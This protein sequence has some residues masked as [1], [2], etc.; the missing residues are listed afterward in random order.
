VADR[1]WGGGGEGPHQ[2]ALSSA[3]DISGGGRRSASR[4]GG[5]WRGWSGWSGWGQEARCGVEG[6]RE[7]LEESNTE[8]VLAVALDLALASALGGWA[9][10]RSTAQR[11]ALVHGSRGT[12]G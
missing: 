4:S 5:R 12:D 7:R 1:I 8:K 10:C 9:R 2:V 6:V 3:E 11:R